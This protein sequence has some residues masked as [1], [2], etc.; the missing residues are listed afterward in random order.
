M[1][2]E[3]KGTEGQDRE[4]YSDTQDR[5]SYTVS[6]RWEAKQRDKERGRARKAKHTF[7]RTEDSD[8]SR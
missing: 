4:S 6:D 2:H 8:G 3:W 7:L 5:E 1:R